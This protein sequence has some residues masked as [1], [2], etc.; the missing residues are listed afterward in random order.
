MNKFRN[1][2]TKEVVEANNF[3]ELFAFSHNSNYEKLEEDN[4]KDK[5]SKTKDNKKDKTQQNDNVIENKLENSND[6]EEDNLT[7]QE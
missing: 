1:I 7:P 4:K 2:T 6:L 5:T 3:T